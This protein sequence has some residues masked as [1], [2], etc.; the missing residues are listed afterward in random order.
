MMKVYV[1]VAVF[2]DGYEE[3]EAMFLSEMA[4]RNYAEDFMLL[5]L[6]WEGT[7]GRIERIDIREAYVE[8]RETTTTV[9]ERGGRES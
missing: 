8:V 7:H 2:Q 3:V 1:V 5:N 4:A 9:V 6:Y